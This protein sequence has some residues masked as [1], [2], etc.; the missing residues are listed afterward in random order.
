MGAVVRRLWT[1]QSPW[2][3]IGAV[4]STALG[5]NAAGSVPAPSG[6]VCARYHRTGYHSL[7]YE[8]GAGANR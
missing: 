2:D 5:A 1:D 3:D 4:V 6:L 8:R 7:S